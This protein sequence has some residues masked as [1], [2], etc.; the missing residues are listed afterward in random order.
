MITKEQGDIIAQ[1]MWESN[2][3]ENEARRRL[4]IPENE[5]PDFPSRFHRSMYGKS[6]DPEHADNRDNREF[7]DGYAEGLTF[8][9]TSG[10]DAIV[11]EWERRGSPEQLGTGFCE[12][13]RGFN[14]ASLRRSWDNAK[15]KP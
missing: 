15:A 10:L 11:D 9:K 5:S 1:V 14:A 12:W 6:D 7:L 2:V 3:S 8:D 4:G 13:K